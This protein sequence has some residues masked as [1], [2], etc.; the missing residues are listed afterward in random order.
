MLDA[1]A[2]AIASIEPRR[3]M[4]GVPDFTREFRA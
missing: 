1:F 4:H 3:T 2:A